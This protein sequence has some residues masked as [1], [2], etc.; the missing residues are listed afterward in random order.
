[1][2]ISI[3]YVHRT[4]SVIGSFHPF[5]G[6]GD[7]GAVGTSSHPWQFPSLLQRIPCFLEGDAVVSHPRSPH[8]IGISDL[9]ALDIL[10]VFFLVSVLEYPLG[11]L[12][13]PCLDR[14]VIDAELGEDPGNLIHSVH[15]FTH[16]R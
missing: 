3:P 4:G 6:T 8:R 5:L 2:P 11:L 16:C 7:A 9:D 15:F 10:A 13:A 12:L 14:F 1:M